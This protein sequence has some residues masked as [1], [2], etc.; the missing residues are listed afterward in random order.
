MGTTA[1]LGRQAGTGHFWHVKMVC[2]GVTV[3]MA[4]TLGIWGTA[5]PTQ[6]GTEPTM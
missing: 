2:P 4:S 3:A 6:R 1:A 5:S